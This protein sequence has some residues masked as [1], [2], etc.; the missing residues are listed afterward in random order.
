M[1][2][3]LRNDRAFAPVAM[4]PINRLDSLFDRFFGDDIGF[5]GQAGAWS[6]APV[7]MWEDDDHLFVEAELP[8]VAEQDVE[9]TVH[10]GMLFIRGERTPVEGRRYLYNGRSFGR[11]E[12]V[13]TLPEAVDTEGV[14]A[15][16]SDGVLRVELPK[17]PEARP[18]RIA[19]KTS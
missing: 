10:N 7:A 9:I 17:S 2:P 12:R 13:V 6:G 11:F 3:A 19:I 5:M 1:L 18:R 16:L 15:T 14:Q 4:G 8:G